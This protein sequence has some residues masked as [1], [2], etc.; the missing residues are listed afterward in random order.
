MERDREIAKLV[1]V[2]Q[3]IA[4]AARHAAWSRDPEAARFCVIQY[5]KVRARMIELEPAIAQLFG[6]LSDGASADVARIAAQELAAYFEDEAASHVGAGTRAY[7]CGERR[8]WPG[9]T[10]AGSCW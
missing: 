4:R 6:V 8:T 3:R 2:L 7:R 10:R 9:W 1:N 5:N